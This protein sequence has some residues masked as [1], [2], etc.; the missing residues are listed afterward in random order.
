MLHLF[1]DFKV[2][3]RELRIILAFCHYVSLTVVGVLETLQL[4][5]GYIVPCFNAD[6]FIVPLY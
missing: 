5:V 1:F 3:G 2:K 6:F 4:L